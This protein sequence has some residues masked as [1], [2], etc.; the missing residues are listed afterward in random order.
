MGGQCESSPGWTPDGTRWEWLACPDL[1]QRP[2]PQGDATIACT[3][4]RTEQPQ[5]AR[6]A[7]VVSWLYLIEET[8]M[9]H[10]R[11]SRMRL[12]LPHLRRLTA[13]LQRQ[14]SAIE[15][16]MEAPTE[17]EKGDDDV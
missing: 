1:L 12:C 2:I 10:P 14:L 15:E 9:G 16:A 7:P 6:T 8:D 3:V 13:G 5:E 4:C 17:A 11:F